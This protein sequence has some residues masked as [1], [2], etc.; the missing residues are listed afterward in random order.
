MFFLELIRKIEEIAP[1]P[2]A[3]PWD[4]S[5]IQV[6][7]H[8][9]EVNTLAV[10]LDPT[11]Q[12][13]ERALEAGADCLL[14]H[15]PLALKPD[16][17]SRLDGYRE[18]LRLLLSSDTP[19]YA[20]HTSLDTNPSGPAGWLAQELH[21]SDLSLLET[22]SREDND[23]HF[24]YGL[25]GNLPANLSMAELAK[26][27]ACHIDLSTAN[28][29]GPCPNSIQR[30]AYCTGAG[31]SLSERAHAVNAD[32]FITGDVKYHAALACNIA[33]LDV[34]HHSLEEEMMRRMALWLEN[35]NLGVKIIFIP[36]NSPFKRFMA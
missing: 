22:V 8:R 17:P 31:A 11:P 26:R 29:S 18:T 1:L 20:A 19:L 30:V 16:L 14:S 21:L 10:C 4:K 34:G 36:S 28:V 32:I 2:N 24:G 3:A 5:G 9:S 7:A 35:L 15:H 27:L 23:I 6:A 13:V 33:I 25:V 12:S